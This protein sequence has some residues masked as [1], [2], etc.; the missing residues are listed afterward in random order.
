M[1]P[2]FIGTK[3]GSVHA[4]EIVEVVVF[5]SNRG[6]QWSGT[7]ESTLWGMVPGVA[8][9]LGVVLGLAEIAPASL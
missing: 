6:V 3:R 7:V 5:S 4:Q 1:P 9:A 2:P 8:V